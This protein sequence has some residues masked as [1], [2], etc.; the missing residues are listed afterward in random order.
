MALRGNIDAII[1]TGGIARDTYFVDLLRSWIEWIGPI[2]LIPGEDEMG[3]LATNA[4]G[5]IDGSLPVMYY[6][7]EHP[8]VEHD[9]AKA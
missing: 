9:L 3:S 8:C 5:A 1:L 4:F 7:P 2:V 6:R